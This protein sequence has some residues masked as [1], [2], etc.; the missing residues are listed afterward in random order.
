MGT[1]REGEV[2]RKLEAAAAGGARATAELLP[3]LYEELRRLARVCMAK[4]PSGNTLQPT[5]LVH[6]AC[7]RLVG[8]DAPNWNGR[9]HFFGAAA[10]AMRQ[11]L[12]DQARLKH[13]HGRRRIDLE[14]AE[15]AIEPP[16]DDVLA[17]NEAVERLEREN[18]WLGAE[19]L[20]SPRG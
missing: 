9:G 17:L 12:V 10:Q 2:T 20:A 19:S 8:K 3:L 6:E 11:I 18:G 16:T 4:T 5:A 7:L 13:G 1:A 14:H 15:P